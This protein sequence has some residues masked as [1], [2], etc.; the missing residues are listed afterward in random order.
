MLK[1]LKLTLYPPI[2]PKSELNYFC[3]LGLLLAALDAVVFLS[4]SSVR[5][6]GDSIFSSLLFD[7]TWETGLIL[8]PVGTLF[9]QQQPILFSLIIV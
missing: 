9:V 7:S 3:Y 6:R 5:G 2:G 1:L 4:Y 8:S